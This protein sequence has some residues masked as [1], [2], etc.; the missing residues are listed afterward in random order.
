MEEFGL[1]SNG[2]GEELWALG[3]ERGCWRA[4]VETSGDGHM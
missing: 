1:R 3:D 4:G 2:W